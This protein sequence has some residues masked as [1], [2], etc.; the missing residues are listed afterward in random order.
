M[1]SIADLKAIRD[2]ALELVKP[3]SNKPEHI[4]AAK[5]W[6][7][8]A[9]EAQKRLCDRII[10]EVDTWDSQKKTTSDHKESNL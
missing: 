2:Y 5:Q 3:A 7:E 4:Q 9:K 10:N 1:S 6:E 8:I